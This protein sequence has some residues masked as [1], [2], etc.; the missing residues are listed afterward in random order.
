MQKLS[1]S[2]RVLTL[3]LAL[4]A[5][6]LAHLTSHLVKPPIANICYFIANVTFFVITVICVQFIIHHIYK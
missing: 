4:T 2:F 6:G 3:S 1:L 5:L